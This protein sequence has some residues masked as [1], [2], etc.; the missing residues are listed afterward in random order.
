MVR[1]R[2]DGS[3]GKPILLLAHMDVV[4]AKR[5]DWERDPFKL[6]EENG[7]FYGRGTYDVKQGVTGAHR[8]VPAPQGG[9][10]SCRTAT[11]S[12]TSRGD[13]ET[14]QATTV[15]I[16]NKHRDLIDAEFALN[17]RRRA[18]ARSTMRPGKPLY[19]GLQTAEK[20][21]ADFTLTARNPGR[22][23]LAAAR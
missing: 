11:S 19:F 9:R 4:A 13:E 17:S 3:G 5:E 21:Y 23:Q 7:Y 10:S 15:A 20:T 22:P 8:A 6:I 12:S 16:A 1:Y 18:A 14:S 2:G